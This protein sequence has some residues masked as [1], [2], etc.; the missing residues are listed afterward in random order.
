M[1]FV[2]PLLKI[3]ML[4]QNVGYIDAYTMWE[5]FDD[6]RSKRRFWRH[7]YLEYRKL[8]S[9]INIPIICQGIS[10]SRPYFYR[11]L[12]FSCLNGNSFPSAFTRN[13][14]ISPKFS[15]YDLNPKSAPS[16]CPSLPDSQNSNTLSFFGKA[17]V[18]R[19]LLLCH[20]CFV[21]VTIIVVVFVIVVVVVAMAAATRAG[22]RARGGQR[23]QQQQCRALGVRRIPPGTIEM[24]LHAEEE[25]RLLAGCRGGM[26][27]GGRCPG[28]LRLRIEAGGSTSLTLFLPPRWLGRTVAGW[29]AVAAWG[30]SAGPED[31]GGGPGGGIL[32][33]QQHPRGMGSGGGGGH[34]EAAAPGMGCLQ[35]RRGRGRNK[36]G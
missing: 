9:S 36:C 32:H 34:R 27:S 17:R 25:E 18:V 10:F 3:F 35:A 19:S 23:Q 2:G 33:C 24:V 15:C 8:I 31:A 28:Q 16:F 1:I 11:F 14:L 26:R 7:E 13:S 12:V 4:S 21:V 5:L 20:L 29:T 6:F 22:A 30:R